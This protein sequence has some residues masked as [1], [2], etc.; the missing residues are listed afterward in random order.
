[1]H[2]GK[3]A[4]VSEG[5]CT[6]LEMNENDER[7]TILLFFSELVSNAIEFLPAGVFAKLKKLQL[8]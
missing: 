5:S 2:N 8:L 6:C 4:L 7:Q 3:K 1:M